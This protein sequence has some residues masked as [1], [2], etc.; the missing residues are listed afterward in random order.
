MLEL[1]TDPIGM[2]LFAHGSGSSRLSPRNNYVAEILR[3]AHIGTLLADLL[4]PHEDADYQTRFDI[5]LLSRR[6]DMA[7]EW[8]LQDER[9]RALPLG[10]FGASTGAAAALQ[11]AAERE[12]DITALVSRGGRVDLAGRVALTTLS[13]PALLIV[14]GLDNVVIDL[15]RA[16]FASMH[17]EKQLE[18]ISGAGHLFEERGKLDIVAALATDWFTRHMAKLLGAPHEE[19]HTGD[20]RG[21]EDRMER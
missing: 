3:N 17:C 15:N 16:A 21:R 11:V 12:N 5:P 7:V 9:T 10:L 19:K 14:G 6:L 8:L 1:P 18:I 2:V 4:S 20:Y 13:A